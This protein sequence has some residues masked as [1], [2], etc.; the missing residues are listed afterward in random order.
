MTVH[1]IYYLEASSPTEMRKW[2]EGIK[3]ACGPVSLVKNANR[4]RRP[5]DAQT[6]SNAPQPQLLPWSAAG[7]SGSQ[8]AP[9]PL[10]QA[11][12]VD[13]P[14]RQLSIHE[15]ADDDESSDEDELSV[16]VC[17]PSIQESL[18]GSEILY[19]GYL[20][21]RDK[22]K[23]WRKR[24]FVLRLHSLSYYKNQKEN[25]PP[26]II[27]LDHI[28]EI[29]EP[30]PESHKSKK[31]CFCLCTDSRGYWLCGDSRHDTDTWVDYLK[32]LTSS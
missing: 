2:V 20:L 17:D 10:Y 19:R 26:R 4:S 7:P 22:Y 14:A 32:M 1:K 23:H 9:L 3:Q 5:S 28:Q 11:S 16:T 27:I 30:H 25:H 13:L 29:R 31:P 18:N 6:A 24:W 12:P 15:Y 8:G 21:K